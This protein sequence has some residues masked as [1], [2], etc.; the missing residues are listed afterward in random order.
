MHQIH[1]VDDQR[2]VGGVLTGRIGEL[3]LRQDGERLQLP[4]PA[5]RAIARHVAIK[6]SYIRVPM[7]GDLLEKAVRMGGAGIVAID[8]HGN[9]PARDVHRGLLQLSRAG[10]TLRSSAQV[11][12][13]QWRRSIRAAM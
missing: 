2:D 10:Y 7:L 11:M 9:A 5:A 4:D 8:Q 12:V 6:S 13:E 1:R 3:L